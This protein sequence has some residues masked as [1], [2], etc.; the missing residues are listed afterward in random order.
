M[1]IKIIDEK[2]INVLGI[3]FLIWEVL[4]KYINYLLASNFPVIN[5]LWLVKAS[6][7][8]LA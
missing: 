8:S 4:K 5:F 7:I 3:Y 1:L 6:K 2:N